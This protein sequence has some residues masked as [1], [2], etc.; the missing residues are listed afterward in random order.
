MKNSP[1]PLP[2]YTPRQIAR[3]WNKVD[4]RGPE[5]C[6]NWK[7]GVESSGYGRFWSNTRDAQAH[8]VAYYLTH[9][10]FDQSLCILHQ[11]D[12]RLCCNPAHL[13]TGTYLDNNR[14][15]VNKGRFVKAASCHKPGSAN[16]ASKLTERDV[17][18]IRRR[19]KPRRVTYKMLGKEFGI[20]HT[21]VRLIV[22]RKTW[23][24]I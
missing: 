12:N 22:R 8:R 1:L 23:T 2:A 5:E 17:L 18:E 11:C 13:R 9:L 20:S 21:N 16:P 19:H 4:R 3:F 10:E 14:D 7:R 24:H 15:C 6:W